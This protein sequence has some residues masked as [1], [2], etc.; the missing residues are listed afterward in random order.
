MRGMRDLFEK[1][2]A[3]VRRY[4]RPPE[5]ARWDYCFENGSREQVVRCL[6][7]FQNEDGGFGHGLEPDFWLPASSPIATWT[8]GRVLLEIG[9]T[10]EDAVVRG[11]IRYL[12]GAFDRGLGMWHAVLPET[13]LHP[14]APWWHWSEGVQATWMYNPSV[15]LAAYLVH[16]SAEGSE[17]SRL[18]WATLEAAFRYL[19]D[20]ETLDMHEANTFVAAVV[21][22]RAYREAFDARLPYGYDL[23]SEQAFSLAARCVSRDA[24]AWGSGY[25]ALPLDFVDRPGHPMRER[26]G[27]LIERNLDLYAAQLADRDVWDIAWGWGEYPEAYPVARRQWQGILAVQRWKLLRAFGRLGEGGERIAF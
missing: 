20:K 1:S 22:L 2:G 7:A 18:G 5:A 3:W 15:E 23:V 25:Q 16:W 11:M 12:V 17:A 26:F 13:N 27:D 19:M 14:H 24:S 8:A 21:L 6:A 4:S 10:A 9:A